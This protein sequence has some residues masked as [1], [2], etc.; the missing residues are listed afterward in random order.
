V[1]EITAR[2]IRFD[3]WDLLVDAFSVSTK[4]AGS[5]HR[6]RFLSFAS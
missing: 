4:T 3:Q 2:I 1:L 6:I 5:L